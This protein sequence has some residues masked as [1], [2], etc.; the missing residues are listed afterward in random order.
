MVADSGIYLMSN[1]VP[2]DWV[3]DP[4]KPEEQRARLAYADGVNPEKDEINNWEEKKRELMGCDDQ[5]VFLPGEAVEKALA[6]QKGRFT[7]T[8][9]VEAELFVA[10]VSF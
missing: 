5:T 7:I 9:E 1:G 10:S 3:P 4:L 2:F 8:V 6:T